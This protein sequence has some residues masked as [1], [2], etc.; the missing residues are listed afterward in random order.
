MLKIRK[1][2][3]YKRILN[4]TKLRDTHELR[5]FVLNDNYIYTTA[6]RNGKTAAVLIYILVNDLHPVPTLLKYDPDFKFIPYRAKCLIIKEYFNMREQCE[7]HK[8]KF[9]NEL[10]LYSIMRMKQMMNVEVNK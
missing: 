9:K 1:Y 2:I 8:I 6:R 7:H 3:R 5:E 4:V 10:K